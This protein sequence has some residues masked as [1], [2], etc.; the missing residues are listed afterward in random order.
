MDKVE[1]IVFIIKENRSYDSYF[2]TLPGANGATKGVVSNGQTISLGHTPDRPRDMGHTWSDAVA[3]IDGGKMDKFDL[4]FMGNMNGDYMSMSQALESDIPNYFAYARA[5]TL[6]DQMFSSLQGPSFPNH[7]YIV[8][9]QSAG[10]IDNPTAKTRLNSWGCDS[11]AST[12]VRILDDQ[13]N[14]SYVYPCF[15]IQTVGD[16]L[17]AA[18]V[19]WKYYSPDQGT[20]GYIWSVYD[21]VGHIRN[22][23]AWSQH[24]FSYGQFANDA[25][26][27]NLPAV[28]WVTPGWDVSEHPPASECA[29]ENWTVDQVN[30]VMQGPDWKN[31]V[32]F[33]DRTVLLYQVMG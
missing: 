15:E 33:V 31:T 20:P 14:T 13:G 5:F 4:V 2:G 26:N 29:G 16:T 6:A 8:S 24:V 9:A 17:D 7:L 22:T 3:A 10:V 12:T 18:G 11:P 32:I 25:L 1:H 27:G 23:S 30:A 21:A 28:S 19:S